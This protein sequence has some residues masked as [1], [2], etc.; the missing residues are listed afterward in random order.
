VE[1]KTYR[2]RGHFEGDPQGYRSQKEIESF[3]NKSD[4][5]QWFRNLLKKEG[6]L[7]DK[8]EKAIRGEV[9]LQIEEAVTYA[10]G[11]PLPRPEEALEDL[12][13]NP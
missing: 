5:I 13:V 7:S 10:K 4:P 2:Y 12:F 9:I 8:Q 1:N 11:A 3:K 6:I